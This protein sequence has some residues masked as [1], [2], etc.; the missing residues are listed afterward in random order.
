M[1]SLN[2]IIFFVLLSTMLAACSSSEQSITADQAIIEYDLLYD[3][4]KQN[5][6]FNEDVLPVLAVSR[7]TVVT[8]HLAS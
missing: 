4:P 6:S 5:L 2:K 3:L 8:M 1:M 7:V